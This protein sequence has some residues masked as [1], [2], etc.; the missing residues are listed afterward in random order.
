M[1]YKIYINIYKFFLFYAHCIVISRFTHSYGGV[2]THFTHT[3]SKKILSD[4]HGEIRTLQNTISLF[5]H[6]YHNI[7]PKRGHRMSDF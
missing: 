5:P 7:H 2:K 3:V 1:N 4:T 6:L